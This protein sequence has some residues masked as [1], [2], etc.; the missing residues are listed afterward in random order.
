M[1]IVPFALMMA[2]CAKDTSAYL[3]Q[4]KEDV[5]VDDV[6]PDEGG[7][8]E[9][10]PVDGVF[11]PGVHP[12]KLTVNGVERRFK[13]YMPVSLSQD[14]P[15]SVIFSFHGAYEIKE[16]A[17]PDP[18]QSI[19]ASGSYNQLAIKENCI[20][21]YP[22]G[23]VNVD[24]VDWS[25][26]N[27]MDNLLF[28]DEM[29]AYLKKSTPTVDLNRIYAIG[30]S[31]GAAFINVIAL[32]RPEVFAAIAP[33]GALRFLKD[34]PTVPTNRV[35][36]MLLLLGS[37]DP[38]NDPNS[39]I[40]PLKYDAVMA[41]ADVWA[42]KIGGYFL[43]DKKVSEEPFEVDKYNKKVETRKYN[44]GKADMEIYT[45]LDERIANVSTMYM[46]KYV[47]DFFKEHTLDKVAPLYV[48]ARDSSI[49][50][51]F[52]QKFEIPFSYTNGA[53]ATVDAP[54]DWSPVV[55]GDVLTL[56]A[57]S[58]YNTDNVLGSISI[59]VTKDGKSKTVEIPYKLNV[60]KSVFEVGDI[61]YDNKY[62]PVG[63]VVWVNP[64]NRQE[65]KILNLESPG[66]YS[67]I[68]FNTRP[69]GADFETPD[70]ND[71]EGNTALLVA[72]NQTITK[73]ND[74]SESA[75]VWAAE[76]SYKGYDDWYLPAINE[77][78]AISQN[79]ALIKKVLAEIGGTA[80][81][82]GCYSSTVELVDATAKTK[83]F[84]YYNFTN[85]AV[86]VKLTTNEY[87]AYNNARLMKK[88]TK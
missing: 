13:Y 2:S 6:T 26:N 85:D 7:G 87:T 36:P 44:G 34:E 64:K 52:S 24:R 12:V 56:T 18:I 41:E 47:W 30:N 55:T 19:T 61:Y 1:L 42:E 10:D 5:K 53:V 60:P 80:L 48:S 46:S 58:T 11:S 71:G 70:H 20:I 76:Y 86:Q 37:V 23:D 59:K 67:T 14:K 43:K 40:K 38:P 17:V 31:D 75:Y 4:L 77:L 66:A 79:F 49:V 57:P 74:E 35:V 63:V 15:I 78:S 88:V 32:H 65:A 69:I 50:S 83:N 73:P 72:K 68:H 25:K 16:G 45:V 82:G 21:I 9:E 39:I 29:I 51:N 54:A 84:Y 22:A 33:T 28:V 62:E 8:E 81:S 3:P 27:Y